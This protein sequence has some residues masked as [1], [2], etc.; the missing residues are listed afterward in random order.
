[1]DTRERAA[2][3]VTAVAVAALGARALLRRARGTTPSARPDRWHAVTVNRPAADLGAPAGPWPEPL[4]ALLPHVEVTV[5]AAPGGRGSELRARPVPA[6]RR[7]RAD[8]EELEGRIRDALRRSRSLVETGAV[9]SS[10]AL[11]TDEWT[12][13]SRPLEAAIR[14]ARSGGRL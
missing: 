11:D 7:S 1:M 14:R 6:R 5:R 8:A 4:A 12:L 2:A 3:G 9:L 10:D 13:T